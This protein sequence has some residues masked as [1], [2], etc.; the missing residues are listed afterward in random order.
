MYILEENDAMI[1]GDA[2]VLYMYLSFFE[3]TNIYLDN[4]IRAKDK[5]WHSKNNEF[6]PRG[7]IGKIEEHKI[8]KKT[9]SYGQNT[10]TFSNIKKFKDFY[11][12]YD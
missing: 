7:Y 5:I 1:I 12:L 3:N 6:K 2:L 4:K 11:F 10:H 8:I 9:I